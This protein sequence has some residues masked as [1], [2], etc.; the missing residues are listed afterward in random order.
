MNPGI[1][2]QRNKCATTDINAIRDLVLTAL[3]PEELQ[4]TRCVVVDQ[5]NG[6][7]ANMC[8]GNLCRGSWE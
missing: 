8:S 4:D 7:V 5:L 6:S 3:E 1:Q 2:R